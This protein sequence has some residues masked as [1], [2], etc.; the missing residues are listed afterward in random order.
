MEKANVKERLRSEHIDENE[1]DTCDGCCMVFVAI[2]LFPTIIGF[3][4]ITKGF[5]TLTPNTACIIN[6]FG[7]Y[8]GTVKKAGFHWVNPFTEKTLISLKSQNYNSPT[9]KVNDKRGNPINIGIVVV[10][11][12]FD[13]VKAHFDVENFSNYV[14][15]QSEAALRHVCT[16]FAYDIGEKENEETMLSSHDKVISTLMA[17]LQERLQNAGVVAEEARITTLA[18]APEIS[19][20]ML[21]RQ[22]ASAVIAARKTIVNG[23]IQLIDDAILEIKKRNIVTL[24]DEQKGKLIESMLVVL[25]SESGVT[26]TLTTSRA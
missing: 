19:S 8:K 4:I 3:I 11:R 15:L 23:A 7:K 18:Y 21:K 16:E 6:L 26:P 1:Y 12:V 2:L 14:Y 13:C 24:N 10:W 9:L 5:F 25:C 22:Q 17:E 20:V